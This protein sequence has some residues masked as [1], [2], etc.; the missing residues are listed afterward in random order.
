MAKIFVRQ[1]R[2]CAKSKD[3]H[4]KT[5]KA[6][7]LGKSGKVNLI[8]DSKAV[9]GMIRAVLQWVEVKHV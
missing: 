3:M 1:L 8:N 9:R 6:L 7:G 4:V 5:L 2:S